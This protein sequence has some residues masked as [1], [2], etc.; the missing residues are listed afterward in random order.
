MMMTSIK[1][2]FLSSSTRCILGMTFRIGFTDFPSMFFHAAAGG[3]VMTVV[4]VCIYTL[5]I[6]D[7]EDFNKACLLVLI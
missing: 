1:V 3:I 5:M 2:V 7:D 6:I 4:D